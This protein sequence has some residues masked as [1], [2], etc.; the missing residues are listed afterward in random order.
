MR[1]IKKED[2]EDQEVR[3]GAASSS[4]VYAFRYMSST[5]ASQQRNSQCHFYRDLQ[6]AG[7]KSAAIVVANLAFDPS[8]LNIL[9]K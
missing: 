1:V 7:H 9:L 8:F 3:G 4:G 6:D 5:E 2:K